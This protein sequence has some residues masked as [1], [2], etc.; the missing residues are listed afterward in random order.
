VQALRTTAKPV[1]APDVRRTCNPKLSVITDSTAT[2]DRGCVETQLSFRL[3]WGCARDLR[4]VDR[5]EI[6]RF[7]RSNL[8]A[9][10]A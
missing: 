10:S 2:I 1:V 9:L 3:S 6:D 7:L 4:V 8:K 5:I